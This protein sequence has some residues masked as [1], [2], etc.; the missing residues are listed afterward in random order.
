[1]LVQVVGFTL[2]KPIALTVRSVPGRCFHRTKT[3]ES[4]PTVNSPIICYILTE[5]HA[6]VPSEICILFAQ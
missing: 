4:I 2:P 1:M 3:D 6:Y 5:S